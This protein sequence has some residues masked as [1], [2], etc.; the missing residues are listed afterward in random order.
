MQ[1]AMLPPFNR[2][3]VNIVQ[4]NIVQTPFALVPE[5]ELIQVPY[6]PKFQLDYVGNTGVGVSAGGYGTGLAG[7]VNGL[8]SDILG[9]NQLFGA[10]ALNGEIYDLA[11]QFAYMN[12]ARKLNW[13]VS[14][15][16]VPF[17]SGAQY[18]SQ[19]TIQD[20]NG[21]TL[22][23]LN[24][25]LDL[26]RTFQDQVSV[27][28]SLPYSQIRRFEAGASVA[29]YYYRLD[30]YTDY[31]DPTGTF[32]IDRKKERLSTPKGFSF[33]Q[34]Y[35]A[36]VGDNSFFGVA[37]PLAGHRFRFE[38]GQYL[39][40]VSMQSVL[41]DVRKYFRITPL[42]L[43]ARTLF[44]A[45][46]GKDAEGNILPPLYIGYPSLIR[47]YEALDFAQNT[48]I[49]KGVTINDLMG[50]RMFVSNL[51]L[52]YPLSGPER[53]SG[54]KSRFFLS[55]LNLF[56]DGGIAWG[57]ANQ[58]G[59]GNS[60]GKLLPSNATFVLSTGLSLRVNL[61][62]YLIVEPY[63]AIPWQNRG[64]RNGTFGLN[65]IPGW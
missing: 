60:N 52:R 61:F 33:A 40:V 20:R 41:G 29:R 30:R 21:D 15:S 3:G 59:E 9:N 46:Y 37:A 44:S 58:P 23:V 28:A 11:G 65:F 64:L 56:T 12:Q 48:E 34:G 19:D 50:S 2:V 55:E 1:A 35:V 49:N 25:S 16:H 31:Y 13:G 43:A 8:F 22:E 5:T 4:P 27:F 45:R 47:G 63:Y 7:G 24:Y 53:L 10:V 51:E 17:L 6:K 42:T 54:I 32:F 62:G 18:L 36:Y 26:L 39:G 57:R 14:A 38:V